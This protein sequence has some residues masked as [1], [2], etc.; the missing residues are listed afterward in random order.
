P[1]GSMQPPV[2]HVLSVISVRPSLSN[3]VRCA[4]CGSRVVKS[5]SRNFDKPVLRPNG[6]ARVSMMMIASGFMVN[7]RRIWR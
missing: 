1:P 2:P 5:K 7:L 4:C 6:L 3:A